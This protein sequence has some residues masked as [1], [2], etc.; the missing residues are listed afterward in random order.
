MIPGFA[1]GIVQL[2]KSARNEKKSR[3]EMRLD[4]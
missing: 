2:V 1:S 4:G 3:I